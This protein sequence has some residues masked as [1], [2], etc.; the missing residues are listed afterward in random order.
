MEMEMRE[1]QL[2]DFAAEQRETDRGQQ[3]T[4][5]VHHPE[6]I[7]CENVFKKVQCECAGCLEFRNHLDFVL[8]FR[9][10]FR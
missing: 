4:G 8:S 2:L 6:S 9:L 7:P 3:P 10:Y 5:R 1:A